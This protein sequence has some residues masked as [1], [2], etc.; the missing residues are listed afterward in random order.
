MIRL[1]HFIR[2]IKRRHSKWSENSFIM[3]VYE[4]CFRYSQSFPKKL[5]LKQILIDVTRVII[6]ENQFPLA[7]SQLSFSGITVGQNYAA[8]ESRRSFK[9]ISIVS[10]VTKVIFYRNNETFHQHL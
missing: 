8:L 2:C 4:I 9:R 6:E 5:Q 7:G 1:A 3:V 10:K